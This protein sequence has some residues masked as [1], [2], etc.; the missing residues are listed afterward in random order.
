MPQNILDAILETKRKEVAEL[1]AGADAAGLAAR[2]QAAQRPR[3]FFSAVTRGPRRLMNLIAEVKRASPSAGVIRENFDPAAIAREYAAAGADAVSVL[4][5]RT[6]FRGSLEHLRAVREAVDL[7]VLRKDFIIDPLQVY[8]SREAGADAILLIAAALPV[9][10]LSDLMIL[11]ADLKMTALVEVHGADEL[12][13]IRSMI[14]F[15]RGGYSVLGI[16]N[17]DLST[18]DVDVNTT[19]RLAEMAGEGVPIVS[20]SGIRTRAEVEKL[21]SAGI[22]AVLIGETLMRADDVSAEVRRLLGD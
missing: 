17:R 6:Y 21:R 13:K 4:T 3:N 22:K 9:G 7:P 5:D 10:L 11:S 1:R 16:N 18:F 12:L 20:E 19:V 8:E 2:A 15:P 14:G